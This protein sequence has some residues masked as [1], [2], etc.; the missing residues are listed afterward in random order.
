MRETIHFRLKGEV[1][2]PIDMDHLLDAAHASELGVGNI[3]ICVAC[4]EEQGG[5]EPDARNYRCEGCGRLAVYGAPE[6]LLRVS[7]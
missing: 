1:G 7:P 4:G 3:G 2:A 5:V 6:L